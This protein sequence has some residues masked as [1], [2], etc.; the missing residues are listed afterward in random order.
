MAE[1]PR[2]EDSP[3]TL[4]QQLSGGRASLSSGTDNVLGVL[5]FEINRITADKRRPGWTIWALYGA[6]ATILW[7]LVDQWEHG[8]VHWISVLQFFFAFYFAFESLAPLRIFLRER[9]PSRGLFRFRPTSQTSSRGKLVTSLL[10]SL[11]LLIIAILAM[12]GVRW[13][14]AIIA[15][16][17]ETLALASQI[18]LLVRNL[19][20]DPEWIGD[21]FLTNVRL[22][23]L[24]NLIV[25]ALLAVI[26]LWVA[27]G[28]F[29][30]A[31]SRLPIGTSVS[32]LRISGLLIA[33][34]FL[35]EKLI[36]ESEPPPLLSDLLSV[37][38]D[39]AFGRIDLKTAI[40]QADIILD[41]MEAANLFQEEISQILHVRDRIT[42]K[43][44][45]VISLC[46]VVIESG[47]V[48]GTL[49]NDEIGKELQGAVNRRR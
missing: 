16:F 37:R 46:A 4:H 34:V 5:D 40:R 29:L 48:S 36:T 27:S 25:Q 8:S 22:A 45:N 9:Q 24:I 38:R 6:T 17:F 7:L 21:S 35:L 13:P 18:W 44:Q 39:L 2:E 10:K 11:S 32:D 47:E 23:I 1:E 31:F 15:I 14:Q 20:N 43:I 42:S 30:S 28:Y 33:L 12:R 26:I 19:Q 41:G 49:Q 3:R